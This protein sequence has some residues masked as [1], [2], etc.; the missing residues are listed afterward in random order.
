LL[1]TYFIQPDSALSTFVDNYILCTSGED[2]YSFNSYWPASNETNIVF[3]LGDKPQ[4][5]TAGDSNSTLSGKQNCVIGLSTRPNGFTSFSGRFH[6]FIIDFK[7]NGFNKLFRIPLHE[8]ANKIFISGDVLG[9]QATCLEEQLLHAVNIRQMACIAD[10]FLLS[11][12]NR[13][14]RSD[15]LRDD[16][17]AAA[18]GIL[19]NQAS[20]LNIKQCAYKANMS[21]RNFQRRFKEQIGIS[22]K[23]YTKIFRFNE[24][25]KLRIMRPALS[26]TSIAYECG[27]FDQMH[28]I[29]D[30]KAFT[31]FTPLEFSKDQYL[32]RVQM[33]PITRFT[34]LEFFRNRP[35]INIASRDISHQLNNKLSEEQFVFVKRNGF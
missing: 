10:A 29:K 7:A 22:P 25:V 1:T 13:H 6:T 20:P 4:H 30:F 26:W 15:V 16:G 2:I 9:K 28:L 19:H 17:I 14:R 24:V 33:M 12:L 32:Q 23:L 21:V 35:Q 18:S 5:N 3:Y 27:Y 31:G 11:F 34:P 8:L